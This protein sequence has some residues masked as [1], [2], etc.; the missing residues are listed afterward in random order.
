MDVPI[1]LDMGTGISAEHCGRSTIENLTLYSMIQRIMRPNNLQS[2]IE[3]G[4]RFMTNRKPALPSPWEGRK[5]VSSDYLE[6]GYWLFRWGKD[7]PEV[8]ARIWREWCD[9]EPGNP[10]NKLD[11]GPINLWRA[12]VAGEEVDPYRV[13]HG[14]KTQR[15]T[16]QQYRFRLAQRDWLK[17]WEPEN[18]KVQPHRRVDLR[19]MPPPF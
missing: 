19:K 17:D 6:E 16:A 14:R 15:L 11:T 1:P 18:P 10:D 4:R 5:G 2:P 8:P 3:A 9:H 7:T 12:E 13:Q